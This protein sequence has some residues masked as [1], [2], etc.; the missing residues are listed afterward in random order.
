MLTLKTWKSKIKLCFTIMREITSQSQTEPFDSSF[1]LA[2][3]NQ[4]KKKITQDQQYTVNSLGQAITYRCSSV[5][6]T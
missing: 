3:L 2:E 1:C 6:I 4:K 5:L